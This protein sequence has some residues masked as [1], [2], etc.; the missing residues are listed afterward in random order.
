MHPRSVRHQQRLSGSASI[1]NQLSSVGKSRCHAGWAFGVRTVPSPP[2]FR[3]TFP[4]FGRITRRSFARAIRWP[5]QT[6]EVVHLAESLGGTELLVVQCTVLPGTLP[7][8]RSPVLQPV[9][10]SDALLPALEIL[11]RDVARIQPAEEVLIL[12]DDSVPDLVLSALQESLRGSNAQ[13]RT[14]NGRCSGSGNGTA[15]SARTGDGEDP[16]R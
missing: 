3:S 2:S 1:H 5:W 11:V 14:M 13:V 12:T 9:A 15:C 16:F 7:E 4:R 6:P 10:D 8:P